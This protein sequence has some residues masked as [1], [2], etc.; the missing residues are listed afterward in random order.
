MYG[1]QVERNTWPPIDHGDTGLLG[2]GV[3]DGGNVLTSDRDTIAIGDRKLF[4]IFRR[5]KL[6]FKA[7]NHIPAT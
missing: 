7:D 2:L 5:F 4:K 6:A 3:G 1:T